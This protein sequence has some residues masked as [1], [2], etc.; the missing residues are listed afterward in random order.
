P[1]AL[2]AGEPAGIGPDLCIA[3]AARER[4]WPLVCLADRELLATRARSLGQPL[5]LED[6]RPEA[7]VRREA[8][9]LT[10]WHAPLAA[11]V[12]A[13]RLDVRNAEQV[14]ALIDRAV[15]GCLA[16]EF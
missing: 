16:G 6:Y 12:T 7:A 9:R 4:P 2:T 8:G 15:D 1:I 14:L 5:A 13:G 11:A 10:V 3:I